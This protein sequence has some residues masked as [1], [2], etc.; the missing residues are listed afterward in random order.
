MYLGNI[1]EIIPDISKGAAH[2][3]T[4]ALMAAALST[5]PEKREINNVLFKDDE[6]M[7]IPEYGCVFQYRCLYSRPDCL[8]HEPKL[9]RVDDGHFVACH[10]CE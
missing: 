3:Y 4:K 7:N 9:V 6:I 10:L 8:R 1:V 5:D 2:P